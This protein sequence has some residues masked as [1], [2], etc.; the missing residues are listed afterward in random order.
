MVPPAVVPL[1]VV[2]AVLP[3]VDVVVPAVEPAVLPE[4]GLG[5]TVSSFEQEFT[6]TSDEHN[7][8]AAKECQL[9]CIGNKLEV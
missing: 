3:L 6:K 2:P 5:L 4:P 7:R 9:C 8:A 1:V